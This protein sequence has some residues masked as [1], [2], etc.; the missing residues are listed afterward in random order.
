MAASRRGDAKNKMKMFVIHCAP[1]IKQKKTKIP[2]RTQQMRLSATATVGNFLQV[3][4]IFKKHDKGA[5]VQ[6]CHVEK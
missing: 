6:A 1:H 4:Y 5:L 2:F 3:K